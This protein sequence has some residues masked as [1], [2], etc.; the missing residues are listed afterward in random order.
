MC[1]PRSSIFPSGLTCPRSLSVLSRAQCLRPISRSAASICLGFPSSEC[2]VG[3]VVGC[4]VTSCSPNPLPLSETTG[5]YLSLRPRHC[6]GCFCCD[7]LHDSTALLLPSMLSPWGCWAPSAHRRRSHSVSPLCRRCL[8]ACLPQ[9]AVQSCGMSHSTCRSPSCMSARSTPP[10]RRAVR[11]CWSCCRNS[12]WI[13]SSPALRASLSQRAS[14]SVRC[15]TAGAYP[16]SVPWDHGEGDAGNSSRVT[17]AVEATGRAQPLHHA[18][19][20]S[21]HLCSPHR[22]THGPCIMR[23]VLVGGTISTCCRFDEWL[24]LAHPAC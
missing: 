19:C 5:T 22:E 17:T 9:W 4:C 14:G 15:G 8:S 1:P 18:E 3:S 11:Y 16:S 24:P 7:C 12:V 10:P 21:D 2:W 20:S 13:S 23:N 6:S